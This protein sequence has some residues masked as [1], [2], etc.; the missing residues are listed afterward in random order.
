MQVLIKKW[1][2][3]FFRKYHIKVTKQTGY[4]FLWQRRTIDISDSPFLF[5]KKDI[6]KLMCESNKNLS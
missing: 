3:K 2:K 4:K 6:V 5:T 1:F